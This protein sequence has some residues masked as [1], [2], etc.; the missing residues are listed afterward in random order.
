MSQTVV[1]VVLLLLLNVG[2][3]ELLSL[4]NARSAVTHVIAQQLHMID[5]TQIHTHT[6]T[7]MFRVNRRRRWLISKSSFSR[8]CVD[9]VRDICSQLT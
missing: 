2:L 9:R 4:S 6:Y 1:M 7:P 3:N 5:H 8:Q